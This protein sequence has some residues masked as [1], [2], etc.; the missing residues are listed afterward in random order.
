MGEHSNGFL[1]NLIAWVTAIAMIIL[2]LVLVGQA[3]YQS[4]HP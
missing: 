1:F 2:T 4:F 3:L